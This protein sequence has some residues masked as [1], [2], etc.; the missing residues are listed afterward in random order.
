MFTYEDRI[1]AVRRSTGNSS[2]DYEWIPTAKLATVDR[3]PVSREPTSSEKTFTSTRDEGIRVESIELTKFSIGGV[4]PSSTPE[5][6][7]AKFLHNYGGNALKDV[8]D[9]DIRTHVQ[10]G[11]SREFC[12]RTLAARQYQ[13]DRFL[14]EY[15]STPRTLFSG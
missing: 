6:T 7:A 13:K 1:R 14:I 5:D 2:Y 8:T 12:E 11:L 9:Q 10:A 15:W 3:T 4:L